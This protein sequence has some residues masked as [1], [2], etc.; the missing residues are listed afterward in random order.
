MPNV[1]SYA[2]NMVNQKITAPDDVSGG[3]N[4]LAFVPYLAIHYA[5]TLAGA[6]KATVA[7]CT[8][9]AP[10]LKISIH[11][12]Y[13]VVKPAKVSY[14]SQIQAIAQLRFTRIPRA[15]HSAP[16]ARFPSLQLAHHRRHS[17]R[18]VYAIVVRGSPDAAKAAAIGLHALRRYPLELIEWPTD[19]SHRLDLPTNIDMQ[20]SLNESTIGLA[21]DECDAMRWDKRPFSRQPAGSGFASEDPIHYLLS[22][23]IG[24]REGL[25]LTEY[26]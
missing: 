18:F 13:A 23:W 16:V 21:R 7:M 25:V 26:E 2:S 22:Y 1:C 5:C 3:D 20:P 8:A 6:P 14:D 17:S 12:A 11:R 4:V 19:N 9:I 24:R 10:E 15:Q